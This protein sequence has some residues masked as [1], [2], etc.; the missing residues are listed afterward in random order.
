MGWDSVTCRPGTPLLPSICRLARRLRLRRHACDGMGWDRM[1]CDG[2]W[3]GWDGMG[4]LRVGGWVGS[5]ERSP[6]TREDAKETSM[7]RKYRGTCVRGEGG[8]GGEQPLS[9]APTREEAGVVR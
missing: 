8:C 6:A 2:V 3:D 5:D 1:R 4:C 7:P 9:S